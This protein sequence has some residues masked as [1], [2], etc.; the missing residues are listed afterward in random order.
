MPTKK[1]ASK[2]APAKKAKASIAAAVITAIKTVKAGAKKLVTRKPRTTPKPAAKKVAAPKKAAAVKKPVSRTTKNISADAKPT[3]L[4]EAY[5]TGRLF[6]VARDPRWLY[7]HWDF[8]RDEQRAFNG[9]NLILR[10]HRDSTSGALVSEVK[11]PADARHWFLPV[12]RGE[13][14][15][16]AE[17]GYNHPRGGW[18]VVATSDVVVTPSESI[19]PEMTALFATIPSGV[20]FKKVLK[21]INASV[22]DNLPLIEIIRQFRDQL[23]GF[24]VFPAERNWTP[25]QTRELSRLA[26]VR[27][28]HRRLV[29]ELASLTAANILTG[30]TEV[31][32]KASGEIDFSTSSS[33]SWSGDLN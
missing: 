4:P 19:A 6:L 15:Y 29:R 16:I 20:P 5:G 18:V 14:R 7:A 9:G 10:V 1:T 31:T 32:D 8:S 22:A 17:L 33:S 23:P 11:L 27:Q 21:S 3:K 24:D 28:I 25:A 12:A 13:T 26:G 30:D 2:K